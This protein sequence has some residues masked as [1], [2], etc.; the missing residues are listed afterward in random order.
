MRNVGI[1]LFDDVEVLDF[2]GPFE[3]FS[4]AARVAA[5]GQ[6]D[7]APPFRV[8]TVAATR[9][10]IRARGGLR[11]EPD[12]AVGEHPP[13]DVLIVPGGVVTAELTKR[14]VIAWVASSAARAQLTAS[15]CTGAFLLGKAGLLRGRCATTHWEDLDDLRRLAPDTVVVDAPRWV[16]AGDIVT[17]AG[18]SAG[19]DMSLHV[20]ARL[21]GETLAQRTARQ[22]DY[23]WSRDA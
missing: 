19:I 15:V 8:F 4:T 12:F 2:T 5:R 21:A 18:I 11:V 7:V 17:S 13:I 10:T 6:P 22:M 16:D 20:V 3:V 23:R 9:A 1:F 14:E